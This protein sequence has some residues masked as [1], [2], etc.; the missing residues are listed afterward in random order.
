MQKFGKIY[1]AKKLCI[2]IPLEQQVC[3]F[4]CATLFQIVFK[5]STFAL[6]AK[7]LC[8]EDTIN[9]YRFYLIIG[10]IVPQLIGQVHTETTLL[11]INLQRKKLF[12]SWVNFI[13][14]FYW[15]PKRLR[16]F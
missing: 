4:S 10:H 6:L 12:F 2:K 7:S 8:F 14:K 3:N 5:K 15:S 13:I 1:F 9:T 16:R 11:S